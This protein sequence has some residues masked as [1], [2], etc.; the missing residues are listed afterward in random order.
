M[1]RD[2]MT[3]RIADERTP[4]DVAVI[5]GGATGLGVAVEAAS[6]GYDV[7]LLEQGDFAQGTS[8]RSTKLIHGGVRYLQRGDIALVIEALHERGVLLQNAPHLVHHRAFIVPTY[9][10]WEG[11]FYGA[12]LK[13]Y[14]MLAGRM[15][16]GPSRHLD[17]EATLARIPTLEPEG[18]RGGIVYYDGQFDDARLAVTL[19]RTLAD[20]GGCPVNYA[21]V[22]GLVKE[23]GMLQGVNVLDCETGA[24]YRLS[25]RVVINATGIFCDEVRRMD[26]LEVEPVI[27]PS[28]GIHIVL[29]KSF[30]PGDA[31]IMVPHTDDGRVLFAVPW[32]NVVVVG[33]TDTPIAKPALS[34]RPLSEE[35][36]F[37]LTH[38]ARYLTRD[39]KPADVRS[40]FAGIRPL[41]R[42]GGQGTA[43]LSREHQVMVSPSGLV[44]IAGGKWT[45][46][47]KMAQD[48]L[49]L[50][51]ALGG[52]EK[53]P[54][55]SEHL[56]LHGFT[57]DPKACEPFITH[58]ADATAL[59]ALMGTRREL[60]EPIHPGLPYRW[61]EVVWAVRYE[62]ARTLSDVLSRRL[63]A[64]LL[65][66][67]AAMAV[68]PRAAALMGRELQWDPAFEAE[69][70][71]QFCELARGYL[72]N[73]V[74]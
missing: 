47:R 73:E 18:L 16:L 74:Q 52:L 17:R 54:S 48:T 64:L 56:H 35:I 7:V 6:R 24:H 65:D 51:A 14:D 20:L 33:T 68:A 27:S 37:L 36:E 44:T 4:W 31:A 22:T 61:V 8:S 40:V 39:P 26:A 59:R 3:A 19:A 70:V 49:D 58:G 11:P 9:E 25:A 46:Y 13:F 57:L 71:R 67:R 29:E 15:G 41:L 45:T 72:I 63:R 34:P 12:G 62:M 42:G 50:A 21:R 55:R 1:K 43:L 32:H 66:A 2:D 10:W 69:Q 53:R 38:A 30:L 5:G 23:R 60:A 28:Q